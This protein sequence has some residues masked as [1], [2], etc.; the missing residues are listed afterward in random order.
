MDPSHTFRVSYTLDHARH[1]QTGQVGMLEYN[2]EPEDVFPVNDPEADATGTTL[3]K[4]DRL[5]FAILNQV[6]GEYRGNFG[7]LTVNVGVRAPFF[8]RELNNYCFTTSAT[9]FVE[10]F[11]KDETRNTQ[12][13]TLNPTV[14][15]PQ[16]RVLKY[17]KLLPNL[18]AVYDVT[19]SLSAFA[20]YTKGLSVPGTDNLYNAFFF[21]PDTEQAKPDPETTDSFDTGL[22]Y[23]SGRVQAQ[24][25]GWF[26]KFNNRL[27]S[28]YDPEL[29]A[30]VF[31]NLGRVDKYGIDGSV[32]YEPIQAL[33][34]YAFGSWNRSKIKENIQLF[35]GESFDCD[36][37][38]APEPT[39]LRNCAF[40]KGNYESGAPKYTYGFSVLGSLGVFD[41]GITAKRT[42]PRYIFDTNVPLFTGDVDNLA[43]NNAA[44]DPVQI[45]SAKAPAY[46]LVNLDARARLDGLGMPRTYIQLN[47]YNLFDKLY[48]GG[49]GGGLNQTVSTSSGVYGGPP[50]VQIGA[51]RTVSVSL[52]FG[53]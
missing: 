9:G 20:S 21:A 3:Q 32:A 34:L 1:R 26:T 8:K 13:A 35:G 27:A 38:T 37:S 45:F 40:T 7:P 4:R 24:I 41:A 30:T 6:A 49:F 46:W 36:T 22:R 31:R 18:G 14:Q 17:D 2:G 33:T 50:F 25:S 53:L 43:D 52:N 44:N 10:C 19:S 39:L 5:S 23:R 12:F 28:A 15:G 47:V 16:K 11:G 42:G 29:N 48:V 51:P